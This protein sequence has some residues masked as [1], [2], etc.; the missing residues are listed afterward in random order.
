MDWSCRRVLEHHTTGRNTSTEKRKSILNNNNN[1]HRLSVEETFSCPQ[2]SLETWQEAAER[3]D[4]CGWRTLVELFQ[5]NLVTSV[6]K[7][8]AL[9]FSSHQIF[10]RIG[11]NGNML[12]SHKVWNDFKNQNK[13]I[14]TNKIYVLK[15]LGGH[16][17]LH[18]YWNEQLDWCKIKNWQIMEICDIEQGI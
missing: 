12:A 6:A 11:A 3:P 16:L 15:L 2:N 9:A 17:L 8:L 18:V 5:E 1:N 7:L 10:C 4:T 13:S 14:N